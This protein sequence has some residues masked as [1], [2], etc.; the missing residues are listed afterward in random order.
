MNKSQQTNE[1]ISYGKTRFILQ[2][3]L[4]WGI[5]PVVLF[6]I[7]QTLTADHYNIHAT[8]VALILCSIAGILYAKWKWKSLIK[9]QTKNETST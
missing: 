8:I 3:G 7:I 5:F 4:A 9:Q 6:S 1:V 2:T